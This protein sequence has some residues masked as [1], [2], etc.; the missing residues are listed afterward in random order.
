MSK[1]LKIDFKI[2]P[3]VTRSGGKDAVPLGRHMRAGR[4][5]N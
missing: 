3:K 4:N 5:K 2:T 1:K